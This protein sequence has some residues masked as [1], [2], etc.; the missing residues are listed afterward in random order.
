MKRKYFESDGEVF[1]EEV[2][3]GDNASGRS[4]R[5]GKY[6]IFKKKN[7]KKSSE[8]DAVVDRLAPS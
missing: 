5:D 2:N 6:D 7:V 8:K 1:E 3:S 4:V